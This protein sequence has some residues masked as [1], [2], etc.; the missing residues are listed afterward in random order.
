MD[1]QL[2]ALAKGGDAEAVGELYDKYVDA[3]YR[4]FYWQTGRDPQTA[5]DLTQ[6][7]F[8]QLAKSIKTFKG[9]SSFKN[10]LYVIAKRQVTAWVRRKYQ[11]PQIPLIDNMAF[12][13]DWIDP[14]RQ[15]Q[16]VKLA[17]KLLT[18]L[19]KNERH[20]I[21]LRYLKGYSVIDA[22]SKLHLTPSNI[23]VLTHRAIKKLQELNGIL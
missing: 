13:E 14:E 21:E 9:D 22:A 5:E 15:K 10:W 23:K 11:L 4:Y 20:V 18:R 3:I 16:K 6:D 19:N 2:I 7:A 1:D 17:K 8:I 12:E